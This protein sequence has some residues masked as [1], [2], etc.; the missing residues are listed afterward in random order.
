[1]TEYKVSEKVARE[2]IDKEIRR[3][4]KKVNLYQRKE[5]ILSKNSVQVMVDHI[6]MFHCVYLNG[7]GHAVQEKTKNLVLPLLF[8][9]IPM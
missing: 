1:M 9:S 3:L 6:R 8:E 4:W 7:D 5:L 2:E